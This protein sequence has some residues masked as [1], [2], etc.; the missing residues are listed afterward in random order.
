MPGRLRDLIFAPANQL[1]KP[2]PLAGRRIEEIDFMAKI[3]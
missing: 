1:S 2:T 3:N